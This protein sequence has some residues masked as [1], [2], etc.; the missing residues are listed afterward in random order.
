MFKVG[1]T[2]GIG[3]G[4]T[5]VAKIFEDL[6]VPVYYAD[7]EAKNLMTHSS[8]LISKIKEEFGENIYKKGVLDTKYLADI[9][10]SD[11]ERLKQLEKLVHPEVKS[12]FLSWAEKQKA[13][14]VIMENAILYQSGMDVL[15][16]KVILVTAS[17]EKRVDRVLKRDKMSLSEIKKRIKNQKSLKNHLKIADFVI[18]NNLNSV[19]LHREIAEINK[20]LNNLLKLS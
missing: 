9:V 10:F 12:D 14:Y 15:M 19:Y 16:N 13:S 6:G 20:K 11:S 4:K 5:T 8:R 17:E 18:D 3:S 7:N 1:L 2:G